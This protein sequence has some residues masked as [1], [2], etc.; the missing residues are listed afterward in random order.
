MCGIVCGNKFK[1]IESEIEKSL[2]Q[3]IHRGPDENHY[4]VFNDIFVGHTRLSIVDVQGGHQPIFNET[5]KN[6]LCG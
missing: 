5:K 4:E 1:I 6:S 3:I 2:T